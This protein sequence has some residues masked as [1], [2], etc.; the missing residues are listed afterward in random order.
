MNNSNPIHY[1]TNFDHGWITAPGNETVMKDDLHHYL[2]LPLT[3]GGDISSIEVRKK[4]ETVFEQRPIQIDLCVRLPEGL[5]VTQFAVTAIGE[6]NGGYGDFT[7][8]PSDGQW[9]DTSAS[10]TPKTSGLNTIWILLKAK[11]ASGS[12][13]IDNIY[14]GQR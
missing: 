13:D 12:I 14:I 1:F 2:S 11:A 10:Y 3:P 7:I 9:H 4:L 8:P 5:E 6:A